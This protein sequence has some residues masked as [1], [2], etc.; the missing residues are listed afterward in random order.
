MR[1]LCLLLALTS[2][3]IGSAAIAVTHGKRVTIFNVGNVRLGMS[4]PAGFCVPTALRVA[5]ADSLAR[6]DERNETSLTLLACNRNPEISP[7][8]NYVLVK[9][10]KF[11]L[12]TAVPKAESLNQMDA[13]MRKGTDPDYDKKLS[14]SIANST[15][16]SMGTRIEMSFKYQY[17]GRDRD[18]IYMAG[19]ISG[20]S[21]LSER[22]GQMVTCLTVVGQR[23]FAVNLYEFPAAQP[24][25]AFKAQVHSIAASIHL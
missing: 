14:E 5:E 4:L 3:M 24:L 23:Y 7:W 16:K 13:E 6:T 21:E 12:H 17:A 19:P 1:R 11:A 25:E 2:I 15:E 22:S 10:P 9:A 20:K 18:C 8:S